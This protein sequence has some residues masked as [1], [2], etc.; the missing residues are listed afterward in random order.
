MIVDLGER[1]RLRFE[2]WST[3]SVSIGSVFQ[4]LT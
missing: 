4:Q 1:T 3:V 2:G